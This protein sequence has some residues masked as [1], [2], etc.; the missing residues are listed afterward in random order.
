MEGVK[1]I[2]DLGSRELTYKLMFYGCTIKRKDEASEKEQESQEQ[3]EYAEARRRMVDL[4]M[5]VLL[6]FSLV[7]IVSGKK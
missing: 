3:G 4:S 1:G 5:H 2:R 7:P 6:F